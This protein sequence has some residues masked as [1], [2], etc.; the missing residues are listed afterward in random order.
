M[1]HLFIVNPHSGHKQRQKLVVDLLK[2]Y[3][4]DDYQIAYTEYAGHATELSTLAAKKG[5]PFV[6]AIGGDGTVNETASGL[7]GSQTAFGIVRT[8]SGNGFARSLGI[9]LNLTKAI[10]AVFSEKIKPVDVGC[11]DNHYF[12]T[13]AGI[14]FDA[15][16]SEYFQ[17][18]QFRGFLPYL[19]YGIRTF[20]R[21][22]YPTYSIFTED[23][24]LHVEPLTI[25]FAN[26][27]EY[28]NGAVI[29]P[30]AKI[31]D[32]LLELCIIERLNLFHGISGLYAMFA[33]HLQKR[34]YYSHRSGM[35][36]RVESDSGSI[37]Y[38][39]D[40][41]PH[42]ARSPLTISVKKHALNVIFKQG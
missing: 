32:G 15:H 29:A 28:G 17:H 27:R 42:H 39:T 22:D 40:G 7:V 11:V 3:P 12:F 2:K 25:S 35:E 1:E 16:I 8:G 24:R 36:F 19:Y 20:F 21:Y 4:Q 13:T 34:G 31:D 37:L 30:G 5:V 10:D 9:P 38:H 33:G 23:E 26:G 6:T 18:N 41:E 14:G